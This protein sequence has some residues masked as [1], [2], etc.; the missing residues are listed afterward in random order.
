MVRFR[1]VVVAAAV[2]LSIILGG[3]RTR[4]V[5]YPVLI[6]DGVFGFEPEWWNKTVAYVQI[7]VKDESVGGP[8]LVALTGPCGE[9][10]AEQIS[11][12]GPFVTVWAARATEMISAGDFRL[13]PGFVPDGFE[14]IIPVGS[15]RF[16]PVPGQ[17]Y[18]IL[19]CLEP[20]GK[21]FYSLGA[22]WTPGEAGDV[23]ITGV[24]LNVDGPFH[25]EPSGVVLPVEAGRLRRSEVRSY[26]ADGHDVGVSYNLPSMIEP[27]TAT[28]YIYP[29]SSKAPSEG[30][31]SL[32]EL[33][34]RG[35]W[36]IAMLH[37]T[38][39]LVTQQDVSFQQDGRSHPGR[40]AVFDYKGQF[41]DTQEE[42]RTHLY[43]F[44]PIDDAW[45][46]KYRITHPADVDTSERIDEFIHQ[47]NRRPLQG[48]DGT[49]QGGLSEH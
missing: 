36:E 4:D 30:T 3:C 26:D 22:A 10:T 19:V 42:A 35:K 46:I 17:T 8:D 24:V 5:A 41:R 15:E 14:R 49:D 33:F 45:V 6:Q 11:H 37:S 20:A 23:P 43:V 18:F 21:G 29:V 2:C 40:M 25:H 12:L 47:L 31:S 28:V 16:A 1:I 32:A 9:A 38:A 39:R 48:K 44:G 34:E 13:V 27:I 7:L